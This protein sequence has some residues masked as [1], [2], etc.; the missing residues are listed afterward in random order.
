MKEDN[1]GDEYGCRRN[2]QS[3]IRF[4]VR[5][6]SLEDIEASQAQDACGEE[7]KAEKDSWS[8]SNSQSPEVEKE[9][10]TSSKRKGIS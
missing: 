5:G 4:S 2:S 1:G 9:G 6:C 3:N 7:D 10:R 8:A